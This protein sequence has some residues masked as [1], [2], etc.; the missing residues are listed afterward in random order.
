[1]IPSTTEDN[2]LKAPSITLVHLL[3]Y[4][5]NRVVNVRIPDF[6]KLIEALRRIEEEVNN[7]VLLVAMMYVNRVLGVRINAVHT[8]S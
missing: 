1:M 8:Y 5:E 3:V 2:L 7:V 6:Q 4:N